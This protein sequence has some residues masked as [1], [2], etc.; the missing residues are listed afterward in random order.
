MAAR[1]VV[2]LAIGQERAEAVEALVE[3]EV[4]GQVRPYSPNLTNLTDPQWPCSLLQ[5]HPSVTIICDE[6]AASSES[7]TPQ[8]LKH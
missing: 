1:Q 8:R 6:A 5:E 2:L 4:I 7:S 3:G